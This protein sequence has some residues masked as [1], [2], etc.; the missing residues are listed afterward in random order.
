MI[1][2]LSF[3]VNTHSSMQ[4]IWP[5]FTHYL[6]KYLSKSK[7]YILS[8]IKSKYF[9]NFKTLIYDKNL[10]F[11]SQYLNSLNKVKEDYCI[12]LNDDYF[13]NGRVNFKEINRFKSLLEKN[14]RISFIRLFKCDTH[15]YTNIE[16]DKNLFLIN[17]NMRN[18]YSQSATLWNKDHLKDLYVKSPKGF[19]GKKGKLNNTQKKFNL[20]TEDEVDKVALKNNVLG[21]YS[22]YGEKKKGYSFYESRVLPHLNSV[23]IGGEWNFI[24]YRNELE[25]IFNRHKFDNKRN[26]VRSNYKDKIYSFLKKIFKYHY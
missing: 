12:T 26:I 23:I 10:D 21:L 17:P 13:L 7:I 3:I 2:N 6:N 19:I 14:N 25:N 15:N 1:K 5:L 20:C 24:E 22:Y 16:I 8:D 11:T 4:D 18:I 9:S